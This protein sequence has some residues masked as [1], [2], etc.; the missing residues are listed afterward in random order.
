MTEVRPEQVFVT[1]TANVSLKASFEV[2]EDTD[3]WADL[4][5]QTHRSLNEEMR[6]QGV[7][8]LR[9]Q[10]RVTF[11]KWDGLSGERE[12]GHT[13]WPDSV[14]VE[15]RARTFHVPVEEHSGLRGQKGGQQ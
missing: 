14:R 4:L 11:W 2:W 3:R 1:G 12:V 5:T 15:M 9:I 10:R 6:K 8:A 13:E 7:S